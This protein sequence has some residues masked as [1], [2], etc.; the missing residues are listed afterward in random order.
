[1]LAYFEDPWWNGIPK[2]WSPPN[3]S[4][5]VQLRP[6]QNAGGER[7]VAALVGPLLALRTH[8]SGS[9]Y[10]KNE[11]LDMVRPD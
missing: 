1:M 3:L 4:V 7:A 8:R 6:A 11:G 2:P 10:P 9:S 5:P